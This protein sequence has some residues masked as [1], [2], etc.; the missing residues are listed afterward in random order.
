[1]NKRFYYFIIIILFSL[2]ESE[3]M[4]QIVVGKIGYGDDSPILLQCMLALATLCA[5]FCMFHAM[6][7][8]KFSASFFSFL[9]YVWIVSICFEY[10][11]KSIMGLLVFSIPI[12]LP[13]FFYWYFYYVDRMIDK[14]FFF[15]LLFLSCIIMLQGYYQS[16]QMY[17][18][19]TLMQDEGA[20]SGVYTF[21]YLL[22][23]FLV[24]T[25]LTVK[26][27]GIIFVLLITAFSMKRGGAIALS[28]GLYL[29]Y[30][31]DIHCKRKVIK[32]KVVINAFCVICVLYLIV[33]IF[34]QEY[35]DNII[36]R[37]NL[38]ADDEGS[39]RLEIFS[40]TWKMII[41]SDF[42]SLVFGHGWNAVVSKHEMGLSAHN[43]F[44]EIIY[45]FGIIGLVFYI[46]FVISMFKTAISM[47]RKRSENAA[48]FMFSVGT[49]ATNSL[50]SHII[51]YPFNLIV[52]AAVWGYLLGKENF[53]KI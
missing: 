22:P 53:E 20:T 32:P 5:G 3:E 17:V 4:V 1:M 49:F 10:E 13:I 8:K 12:L 23:F 31:V 25:K 11:A 42:V 29:Y 48:P 38:I 37:M 39:G 47:I 15:F 45:D 41:N 28:L 40:L 51:I 2:Y 44:L 24:S 46:M 30:L 6:P 50:Y 27:T 52:F 14:S 19:S 33:S 43:D 16:Y 36:Q 35:F 21:L 18:M 9:I 34:M 26:I 7:R